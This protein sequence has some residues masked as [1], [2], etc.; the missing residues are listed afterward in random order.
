METREYISPEETAKLE[1][2]A[3]QQ[4]LDRAYG[5]LRDFRE[6][7]V[8]IIGGKESYFASNVTARVGLDRERHMLL[9]EIDEAHRLWQKSLADWRAFQPRATCIGETARR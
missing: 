3:A 5:A 4:R 7:H 9:V 6:Q 1:L 2:D 8:A